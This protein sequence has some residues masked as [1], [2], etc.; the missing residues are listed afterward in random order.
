M[1]SANWVQIVADII[2]VFAE[3]L[4][5][6]ITIDDKEWESISKAWPAPTKT[7]IARLRYEAK[8]DKVFGG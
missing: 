6:V 4:K 3:W 1:A 5:W 8:R 2:P 7:R